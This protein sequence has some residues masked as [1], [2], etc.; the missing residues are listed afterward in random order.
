MTE[1]ITLLENGFL[2]SG[3]KSPGYQGNLLL[4]G[5]RILAMTTTAEQTDSII[6]KT[7]HERFDCRGM[8]IAPGFIDVHTHD[9]ATILDRPDCLPKIS[10]GITTVVVGNCGISLVPLV[11]NDPPPPL[12]LL[13]NRQ[14]RFESLGAYAAEVDRV[15][16]AVNVAA[17]IGHTSLR[18]KAMTD[19][20]RPAR[21]GEIAVMAGWLEKAMAEGALGLSSGVFYHQAFAA[22]QTELTGLARVAAA[23]QGL[24]TSHIRDEFAGILESMQEASDTAKSARLPLILSHHKCAGPSNWGRTIETLALVD[25]LAESQEIGL[26]A[27]PYRAG[28]TVLREDLVDGVID[29]LVTGSVPHP[30]QKGRYLADI[31]KDWGVSQREAARRLIPGG[32]S[33]FQMQ[34]EDIERVLTHPLTMVGSD[35]LPHDE[36]PHPR[37][38]GAFPRVFAHYWRGRN[39]LG[40]E[41]TVHKMTGLSAERFKLGNRG[42]LRPNY[43]ADIVVFDPATIADR[44]TFAEPMQVSDGIEWV[45]VNGGLTYG[46]RSH[47]TGNRRGKFIKRQG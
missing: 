12:S 28:S 5:E 30:E 40:L 27:Y 29:I 21:E 39:L 8:V 19:L 1:T 43:Y 38:W 6:G 15:T 33:Y 10:Q 24:Y 46:R 44:A 26:D 2:V 18:I 11:T 3:D 35:G 25:R 32:A 4:Q 17:L 45:W 23:H 42:L 9:D 13:G 16:P 31:A 36:H 14:F 7:R 47:L 41:E 37:L 20:T 22:D 34:E